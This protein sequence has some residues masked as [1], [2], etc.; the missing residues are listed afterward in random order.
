MK[1]AKDKMSFSK[2]L[3]RLKRHLLL[4]EHHEQRPR[5]TNTFVHPGAGER[6]GTETVGKG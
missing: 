3:G 1:K 5:G 4:D 6:V 2:G